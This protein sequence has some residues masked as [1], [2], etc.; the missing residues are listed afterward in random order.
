M[1][2][3]GVRPPLKRGLRVG[4]QAAIME[5]QGSI[6]DQIIILGTKPVRRGV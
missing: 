1:S 3:A 6:S 2:D 5:A 4:K